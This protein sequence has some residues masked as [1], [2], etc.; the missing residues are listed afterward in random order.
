MIE[1]RKTSRSL[2]NN[3]TPTNKKDLIKKFQKNYPQHELL[4]LKK[5]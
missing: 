1:K 4:N 3:Y 2:A 5:T